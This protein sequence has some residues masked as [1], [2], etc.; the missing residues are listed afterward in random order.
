MFCFVMFFFSTFF[1]QCEL[2]IVSFNLRKPFFLYFFLSCCCCCCCCSSPFIL[3]P[4]ILRP[5]ILHPSSRVSPMDAVLVG[6]G[7]S[8]GALGICMGNSIG[9]RTFVP[10]NISSCYFSSTFTLLV[11]FFA[12]LLLCVGLV[13]LCPLVL[14]VNMHVSCCKK[15]IVV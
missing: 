12:S 2:F 1:Y 11:C 13:F 15:R 3:R 5:S 9:V 7:G 10:H 6:E 4:S 14:H 8:G